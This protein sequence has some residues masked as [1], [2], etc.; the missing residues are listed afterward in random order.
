[1]AAS[2]KDVAVR[3]GVSLGTVSNVLNKPELV[4]PPTRARVEQAIA[5]LGFVRNESARHLRGG[6]SRF[7]AYLMLDHSNPFFTDIATG[8]ELVARAHHLGLFLCT[9][10]NDRD[11]EQ[12]YLAMLLE[13]RT[14]GVLITA[15]D[16]TNELL[17]TLPRLGVPLVFVDRRPD[18]GNH[19]CSVG[20]DDVEGGDLAVS[21]L[22]DQGH[23]RIGFV[24]GP[25]SI[26]Q[27]AD[28]LTGA[29]RAVAASA[30]DAD[31]LSVI[32]TVA[33]TVE[34]GRRAGA[35]V[36]GIP[37][38]RRP[39]AVFCANDLLAVGLLQ[40]VI[41]QGVNVPHE[42]AIVGYDDIEFASA[43]A[44]P[45]TSVRQPRD[46]LGITATELLLE[47][48]AGGKHEHTQIQFVPELVVRSS[49]RRARQGRRRAG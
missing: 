34:E 7:L 44:I 27:V 11:R 46:K 20:V 29:R 41:S 12:E 37:A 32:E 2:M 35:R 10:D 16:Y 47:E 49:S 13:Q 28:R 38:R 36:L 31:A 48:A 9:S 42:L 23:E 39:T 25:Q 17:Q 15:L 14:R 21:H 4:K 30:H 8:I 33:L 3:A 40:E 24:G 19:W 5:E 18:S 26:A 1:M 6:Q 43:A 22:L 45:L